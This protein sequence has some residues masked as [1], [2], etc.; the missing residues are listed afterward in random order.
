MKAELKN[1]IDNMAKV[2]GEE[3]Q[4]KE[5]VPVAAEGMYKKTLSGNLTPEIVEEL[6]QHN[7]IFFPAAA[8]AFGLKAIEAMKVDDKLTS[9]DLTIPMVGENKF[10]VSFKKQ[11]DYLNTKTKEMET[12]Y[13]GLS[14]SLTVQ[15][16]RHNRGA[17]GAVKQELKEAA[18]AAFGAD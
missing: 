6:D 12:A 15:A 14:A 13:G 1:A 18:L 4:I 11:Y 10:D 5:G 17:M 2:L 8:K 3:I 7:A 9:L 16:A